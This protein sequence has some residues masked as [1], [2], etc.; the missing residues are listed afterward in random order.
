MKGFADEFG[1]ILGV[2]KD[3]KETLAATPKEIYAIFKASHLVD[4]SWKKFGDYLYYLAAKRGELNEIHPTDAGE[5]F[6]KLSAEDREAIL[7]APTF[8]VQLAESL[9]V[10]AIYGSAAGQG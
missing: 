3:A 9:N 4:S 7:K 2:E 6:A 10:P 5:W 8:N 1:V